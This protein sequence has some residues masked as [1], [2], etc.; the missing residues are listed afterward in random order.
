[1]SE[2]RRLQRAGDHGPA[3]HGR[4]RRQ[5]APAKGVPRAH[6]A[7]G[8]AEGSLIGVTPA[9]AEAASQERAELTDQAMKPFS[10]QGR[11]P[12]PGSGAA[13]ALRQ[14]TQGRRG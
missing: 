14:A 2:E 4:V 7:L 3:E 5:T 11:T 13:R 10:A 9:E 8:I 12:P 1:M 6:D